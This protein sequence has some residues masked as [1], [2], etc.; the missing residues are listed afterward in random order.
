MDLNEATNL[1]S[2]VNKNHNVVEIKAQRWP[3]NDVPHQR[4]RWA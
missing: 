2:D 3:L 1:I 4:E